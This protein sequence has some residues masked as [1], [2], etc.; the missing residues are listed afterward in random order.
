MFESRR[1]RRKWAL[2]LAMSLG[3]GLLPGCAS[4]LEESPVYYV[5]ARSPQYHDTRATVDDAT[6]RYRSRTTATAP[7]KSSRLAGVSESD[8]PPIARPPTAKRSPARVSEAAEAPPARTKPAP[9]RTASA[10]K[11]GS[12]ADSAS[13]KATGSTGGSAEGA[14]T[15][16]N[17]TV[18]P[19]PG[20]QRY[21]ID[22]GSFQDQESVAQIAGRL[23]DLGLPVERKAVRVGDKT[24]LRLTAGPFPFRA[25]AEWAASLLKEKTGMEGTIIM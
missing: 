18:P 7:T 4:Q 16:A 5:D 15:K 9:E 22:L 21:Y 3:F 20:D 10:R 25:E 19:L 11:K 24:F 2:I 13:R 6:D 17:E 14:V 23:T 12:D 1:Q 8:L